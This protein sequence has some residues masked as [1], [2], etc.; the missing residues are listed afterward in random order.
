MV[1]EVKRGTMLPWVLLAIALLATVWGSRWP[2]SSEPS[3]PRAPGRAVTLNRLIFLGDTLTELVRHRV[4]EEYPRAETSKLEI[5][6]PSRERIGRLVLPNGEP[7]DTN[8]GI[9]TVVVLVGLQPIRKRYH[10]SIC[11]AGAYGTANADSDEVEVAV[12]SLEV[13]GLLEIVD[14]WR[15]PLAY[16]SHQDYAGPP[17]LRTYLVHGEEPVVVSARRQEAGYWRPDTFQLFSAGADGRYGTEDDIHY[18][19]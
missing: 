5:A 3:A 7:N 12:D 18:G 15:R 6:R 1:G 19:E 11:L 16:L 10:T 8:M 4:L 17:R 14:G 9:E 2:T 13:T